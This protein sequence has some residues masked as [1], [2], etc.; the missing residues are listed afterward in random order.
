MDEPY[1][2]PGD[3]GYLLNN[4]QAEAGVRFGALAELFDP[5]TFRHLDRLGLG[6]GMRC[7]EV[8]AGGPSVPLGLA[9]RV[10]PTGTVIATD[11]DTSWTRDVAGGAIEVLAHDVAADPPP[12]GVFDFVHARLVLVHVTDRAEALRRMVGALRPGGWLLL[13]DADPLL[14]PL[15]CPDESGPEQRLA[16]RL[17]SGFRTL[18]AARGADLAYGRTLPRVLREAG[19]TEVGADAYFPITSPACAVLEDATV[20]Q[21]RPRLVAEGL[22]TDEE[23]DHHLTHVA[24]GTLDL[25]TAPLISTWGRRA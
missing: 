3:R 23:I 6:P 9:E 14:Q 1:T 24:T 5:V 18:M 15:L 13:E 17:R 16:N 10:T 4:Q 21:I 11:I 2:D 20:R 8:G 19:L 25:A 22:A 12:P 7:W